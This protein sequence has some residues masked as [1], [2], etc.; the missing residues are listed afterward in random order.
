MSGGETLQISGLPEILRNLGD[1]CIYEPDTQECILDYYRDKRVVVLDLDENLFV[2][3]EYYYLPG[4][5]PEIMPNPNLKDVLY[6]ILEKGYEIVFWTSSG[7][8]NRGILNRSI[9]LAGID[10]FNPN[11]HLFICADN[12]ILSKE[13][14][15]ELVIKRPYIIEEEKQRALSDDALLFKM[16]PLLF[17]HGT[18]LIDDFAHTTEDRVR[19]SF[20]QTCQ[21]YRFVEPEMFRGDATKRGELRYATDLGLSQTT[22]YYSGI[23]DAHLISLIVDQTN[24]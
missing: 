7:Y 24:T 11:N 2:R 20:P 4:E 14:K 13:I 21:L 12:T 6:A 8:E 1:R 15:R 16:T 5:R 3:T 22:L 9:T 18:I 19:Y 17:P 10:D 23:L